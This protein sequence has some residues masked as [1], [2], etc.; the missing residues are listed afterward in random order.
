MCSSGLVPI[1]FA[2]PPTLLPPLVAAGAAAAI[3]LEHAVAQPPSHSCQTG[4]RDRAPA[5]RNR[6]VLLIDPARSGSAATQNPML[7]LNRNVLSSPRVPITVAWNNR[8]KAG[9]RS[10]GTVKSFWRR[11]LSRLR[12]R[13]GMPN[14]SAV[15]EWRR[16][17]AHLVW[18]QGVASSNL[19]SP[20]INVSRTFQ[21]LQNVSGPGRFNIFNHLA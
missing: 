6:G 9:D 15:G 3:S 17:V 5:F 4:P 19:V 13:L 10:G 12:I 1:T 2:I 14:R 16:L 20:T 21:A 11:A 18:D 7:A 8:A